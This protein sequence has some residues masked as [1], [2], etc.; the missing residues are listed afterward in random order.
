[1]TWGSRSGM[2][3]DE[4]GEISFH[5]NYNCYFLGFSSISVPLS[6]VMAIEFLESLVLQL[7]ILLSI[8]L[9]ICPFTTLSCIA[10]SLKIKFLQQNLLEQGENAG[11]MYIYQHFLFSCIVWYCPQF[12][13][14]LSHFMLSIWTSPKFCH[15]A[16]S[17]LS[18][19]K[20][21]FSDMIRLS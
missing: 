18:K 9:S 7:S 16:M 17:L 2:G 8:Y 1:M 21:K 13:I 4:G 14:N 6:L 12:K 3:K 11:Y 10:S 5:F 15:F 20:K 19:K